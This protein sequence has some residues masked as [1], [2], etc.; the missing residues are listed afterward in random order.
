MNSTCMFAHALYMYVSNG[1]MFIFFSKFGECVGHLE[2]A[3]ANLVRSRSPDVMSQLW[4]D[5]CVKMK[6]I[7]SNQIVVGQLIHSS[8]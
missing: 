3:L 2:F 6:Y 5:V 8:G 7:A 4:L 1:N